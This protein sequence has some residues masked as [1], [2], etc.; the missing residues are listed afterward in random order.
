MEKS[1]TFDRRLI[2]GR[3]TFVSS[4]LRDKEQRKKVFKYS[5]AMEPTK[6][7]VKGLS[8]ETTKEEL[9]ILFGEFG[10]V[11]EV[12]MVFHKYFILSSLVGFFF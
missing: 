11:K 12:R 8:F 6:L 5:E 1:L 2:N 7:F 9:E 10:A 3:P 4:V